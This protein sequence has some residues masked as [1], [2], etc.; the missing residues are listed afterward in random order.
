MEKREHSYT[1]GRNFFWS[2]SIKNIL[3]RLEYRFLVHISNSTSLLSFNMDVFLKITF[4]YVSSLMVW[5]KRATGTPLVVQ[6]FRLSTSTAGGSDL[7]FGQGTKIPHATQHGQKKKTQ[8]DKVI[9]KSDH[10]IRGHILPAAIFNQHLYV[11]QPG[12]SESPSQTSDSL[13][14]EA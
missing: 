3:D 11:L 7:I 9:F 2:H 1:V 6:W 10:C 8:N 14:R 13:T 12:L 5:N 4:P